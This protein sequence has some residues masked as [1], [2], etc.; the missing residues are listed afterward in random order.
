MVEAG[1]LQAAAN[2]YGL[3][4]NLLRHVGGNVN[5]VYQYPAGQGFPARILRLSTQKWRSEQEAMA[6]LHFMMYLYDH[7]VSVPKVF[8]SKGEKWVES[9]AGGFHAAVFGEAPGK[10]ATEEDWNPKLFE[11]WG[12]LLGQ[13][14]LLTQSYVPLPD[15]QRR[16]WKQETWM[17]MMRNLPQEETIARQKAYELTTWLETLPKDLKNYGLVHCDLHAKNIFVTK[18]SSITAFDFDDSCYHWFVYDIAIILHSVII[19]QKRLEQQSSTLDDHVAW[20]FTWFM[21]GYQEI[22]NVESWWLKAIPKFLSYRRL[23][24]YNFLHQKYDWGTV[25]GPLKAAWQR[26]K[27]EIEADEPLTHFSFDE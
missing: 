13:M 6:E 12:R 21:K 22:Q 2:A 9:I 16:D 17:D 5:V 11:N 7:G 27:V 23:L 19:R 24:D 1:V 8:L 10:I 14:H 20:F 25:E 18:D 4:V 3:D 15:A 26:M